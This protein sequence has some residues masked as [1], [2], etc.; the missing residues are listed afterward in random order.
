MKMEMLWHAG[1]ENGEM[2]EATRQKVEDYVT[3][4][5]GDFRCPDHNEPATVICHGTRLDSIRFDVKGCC[6]KAVYL[7]RKKLEE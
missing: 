6:Q 2:D 5:V 7:V 4:R 1:G 3:H